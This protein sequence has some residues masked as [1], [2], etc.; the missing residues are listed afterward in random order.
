MK[1]LDFKK[2]K[3]KKERKKEKKRKEKNKSL[4]ARGAGDQAPGRA[5]ARSFHILR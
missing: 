2:K 1:Y 5:G 4:F 3:K